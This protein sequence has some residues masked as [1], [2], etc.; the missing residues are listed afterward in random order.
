[1]LDEDVGH[2]GDLGTELPAQS[3]DLGCPSHDGALVGVHRPGEHVDPD[4]AGSGGRGDRERGACVVAQ[5]VHAGRQTGRFRN[6]ADRPGH[7]GDRRV[8][9]IIGEKRGIS[10]VLDDDGLETG[11]GQGYGVG[12]GGV[13]HGL[14]I[15]AVSG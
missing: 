13:D 8:G 1:M 5:D 15:I 9:D 2:D 4:E 3:S 10:V 12:L 14:E 11:V 6:G 7:G